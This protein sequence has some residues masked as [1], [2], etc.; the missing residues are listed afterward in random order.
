MDRLPAGRGRLVTLVGVSSPSFAPRPGP[1]ALLRRDRAAREAEEAR[2]APAATR[3]AASRGRARAE[4]GDPWRTCFERDRDRVVH[5]KA[6]RRLRHKT[7]VF[8]NPDGDHVATRLTHTLQVAQVA[9]ALAAGL[10]L[11]E[12]LVE[13]I[14]LAHDVGHTP[15][16]HTGEDALAPYVPGGWHHAAQGVRIF[17][18]LE[19]HNLTWEVRDGIR[20][21][22]WRIDPPPH[23]AEG[24]CVRYADRIAYLTH[25]ALDALRTGV[26]R[27]DEVPPAVTRA[28]GPPGSGWIDAFVRGILEPSAETGLLALDPRLLATMHVLRDFMFE[29]VYE[30]PHQARC[31]AAAVVVIRGLVEHYLSHPEHLPATYRDTAADLTTQ[32]VDH[33]AGMTDRFALARYAA[34]V[35]PVPAALDAGAAALA[36]A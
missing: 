24:L 21:H 2:L 10:G 5:A 29:R 11:N 6:F 14:A 35:G 8:A 20:A 23:T 19:D 26:L 1:P 22:T 28:L 15:F 17:E 31:H 30:A 9:R 36:D 16:G 4:E 18:V 3:S 32:V 13:A 27:P 25:D 12:P 34:L 33:V 7:Q